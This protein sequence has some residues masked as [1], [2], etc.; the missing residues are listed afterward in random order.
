MTARR[1]VIS[2]FTR[3]GLLSRSRALSK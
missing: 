3:L 1:L 2:G